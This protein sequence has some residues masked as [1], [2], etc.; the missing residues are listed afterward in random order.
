[1]MACF[2]VSFAFRVAVN[3]QVSEESASGLIHMPDFLETSFDH[4]KTA[5]VSLDAL[6]FILQQGGP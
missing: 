5:K 4:P 1:M 3:R 2:C 6:I